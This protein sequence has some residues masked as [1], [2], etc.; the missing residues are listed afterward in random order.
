M[1]RDLYSYLP[2]IRFE[3]GLLNE[4]C[5]VTNVKEKLHESVFESFVSL[6]YI[7]QSSLMHPLIRPSIIDRYLCCYGGGES[8]LL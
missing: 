4:N 1:I 5:F 2:S 6:V 8:A 7:H 3:R